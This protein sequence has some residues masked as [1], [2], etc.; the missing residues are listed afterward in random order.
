MRHTI[1]CPDA[2]KNLDGWLISSWI[3]ESE[4]EVIY[5]VR[6]PFFRIH[7]QMYKRAWLSYCAVVIRFIAAPGSV[8]A[9]H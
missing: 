6:E 5:G 4:N 1:G 7:D 3:E 2:V 9:L 8:M